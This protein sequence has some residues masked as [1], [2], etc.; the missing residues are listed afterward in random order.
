MLRLRSLICSF[1]LVALAASAT[2][3]AASATT[4][5]V[6]TTGNNT[7]ACTSPSAPC[8]TI[9]AAVTKA[10]TSGESPTIEVAAG[11]YEEEVKLESPADDGLL[12]KGAGATATTIRG[13]AAATHATIN[14]TFAGSVT[15]A[16]LQ[17]VNPSASTQHAI[18]AG[19]HM[20]LQRVQVT[21]EDSTSE[22]AAVE[23]DPPGAI[24]LEGGG[25]T[26][27][28]GSK[29]AAIAA[30]D[31][32]LTMNGETVAAA[33]G[34]EGEAIAATGAPSTIENSTIVD[35]GTSNRAAVIT[36]IASLSMSN[37]TITQSD[38]G[39]NAHGLLIELPTTAALDGV[40]VLM[41]NPASKAVGVEQFAGEAQ[42]AN[43]VVEGAW[44]GLAYGAET[45]RA[46]F[47]DSRLQAN[48][49]GTSSAILYFGEPAPPGLVL[50]RTIVQA[51]PTATEGAIGVL[52]GNVTLDSSEV[53]GGNPAISFG[54]SEGH[55]R[56]LTVS[57]STIDAGTPGVADPGTASIAAGATGTV[58]SNTVVNVQGSILLEPQEAIVT[59]AGNHAQIGCRY[60]DVPSQSESTSEA[61]IACGSGAE[62][63]A[64]S[65]PAALFSEPVA[66]YQLSPSSSAI[67]AVPAGALALPFGLTPSSTD[68]AG[69]ARTGDGVDACFAAQDKGALE[70]Q[71]HL[72]TCPAPPATTATKPGRGAISALTISPTAFFAARKGATISA[73]KRK[74]G[75]EVSYRDSQTAT[76]TFTVLRESSGRRQGKSCRKPSRAN[77]HGKRCKLLTALGSFTHADAAGAVRFHFSGRLHGR[78]L[79]GGGYR[80]QAVPKNAA[81]T[82]AGATKGFTIR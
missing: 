10:E 58:A 79:A 33:A 57:A 51:P 42:F 39:S 23:A 67:G 62:G 16:D 32:P 25:V 53:I 68:F 1:L 5:Y 59:G 45:G 7:N 61:A 37:V 50:V 2:A 55:K 8:K 65:A 30:N 13:P 49:A 81:G 22:Q 80:L 4:F 56:T 43:V 66:S 41:A 63:N 69:H 76:T 72:V 82:G 70:L 75:A 52:A 74:Y 64:A 11:A 40:K 31:S 9:A 6:S 78:A 77:R 3:S 73:A 28:A 18:R 12:I 27:A 35:A 29:G 47:T 44:K 60:S 54:N 38:P 19:S 20:T 34:S 26:M 17:V 46:T 15:L 36:A 71:G 21:Q 48:T 14:E 24:V